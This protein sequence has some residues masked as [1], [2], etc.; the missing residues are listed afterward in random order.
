MLETET[1]VCDHHLTRAG[2][3]QLDFIVVNRPRLRPR[4]VGQLPGIVLSATA[5][6]FGVQESDLFRRGVTDEEMAARRA[7][8]EVLRTLTTW[9]A[10][11]IGQITRSYARGYL[12]DSR[13][14]LS[15]NKFYLACVLHI[16][17]RVL[18]ELGYTNRRDPSGS[19]F[20]EAA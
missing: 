9:S 10:E 15:A 4:Q 2:L 18:R 13:R 17:D 19:W 1:F 20:A 14:L 8:P 6:E 3:N 16:S 12:M 5:E 11:E 7:A